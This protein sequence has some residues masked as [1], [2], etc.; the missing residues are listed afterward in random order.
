[1]IFVYVLLKMSCRL[2]E[3]PKE[4]PR[5]RHAETLDFLQSVVVLFDLLANCQMGPQSPQ[6]CVISQ[7]K[8]SLLI[9]HG[10]RYFRESSKDLCHHYGNTS[11]KL[12]G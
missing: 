7:V 12:T 1:V 6:E 8:D 11:F 3:R 9:V 5:D 4:A 10:N 2:E